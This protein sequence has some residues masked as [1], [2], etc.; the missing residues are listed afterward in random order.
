MER[1]F[2]AILGKLILPSILTSLHKTLM[3]FCYIAYI[4]AVLG[5]VGLLIINILKYE[6]KSVSFF[7]RIY[8]V[9]ILSITLCYGYVVYAL[10]I[11]KELAYQYGGLQTYAKDTALQHIV[12]PYL[13]GIMFGLMIWFVFLRYILLFIE[14]IINKISRS[15]FNVIK[16][17]EDIYKERLHLGVKS[18]DPRDY[19]RIK[20][21]LVFLGWNA[22][23]NV[24]IYDKYDNF[25]KKHTQSCGRSQSGKNLSLQ[26]LI[27]QMLQ[28]NSFVLFIDV[29]QGGDEAMSTVL[30]QTTIE[31]DVPYTY[32]EFGMDAP[33]QINILESK[34]VDTLYEILIQ[35][36]NLQQTSDMGTDF[37]QQQARK[38]IFNIAKFVATSESPVTITEIIKVFNFMFF[39][40]KIKDE[41]KTKVQ[42]TLEMFAD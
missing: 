7:A 29:K 5:M 28:Y 37:Y 39:Q 33:A 13:F 23:L 16:N 3:G 30:H 40:Q 34:D 1:D 15:N 42:T 26:P 24:P 41:N 17:T 18:Y 4:Y 12:L 21:G 36:C 25:V 35:L 10:V 27:A 32:M 9:I 31:L 14:R 8:C 11:P 6:H 22:E 38:I 19:F 20:E 2:I